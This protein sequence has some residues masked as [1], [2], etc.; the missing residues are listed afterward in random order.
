MTRCHG[1]R[2]TER[3]RGTITEL[4]LGCTG[5]HSLIHPRSEG[6]NGR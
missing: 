5:V 3:Y 6:G 2:L 4:F 1:I